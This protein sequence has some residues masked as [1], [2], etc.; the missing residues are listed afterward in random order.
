M[1]NVLHEESMELTIAHAMRHEGWIFTD[2]AKDAGFD[3]QYGIHREDVLH[4]LKTQHEDAFATAFPDD[5]SELNRNRRE[6]RLLKRLAQEL[7]RTPIVDAVTKKVSGG[8]L[9]VLRHGFTFAQSDRP[10]ATFSDLVGFYPYDSAKT[11]VVERAKANRLRVIQQV[12]FDT[13]STKTID[14]V[15]LVNGIPIVTMELKTDNTQTINDAIDQYMQKRKP[16]AST[17]LLKPGRCLVHLAVSST[18]V[19]MTTELKGPDTVFLPFNQGTYDGRA[20]NPVNPNGIATAYLWEKVFTPDLTLRIIRDYALWEPSSKGNDGRLI[21]PRFHQ[22][23]SVERFINDVSSHGTGKR[24]LIQH[25]AG[26]GKTKTIAWMAH[27]ANKLIAADGTK[28]YDCVIVVTDRTVLDKNVADGLAL[29][30][31]SEGMVINISNDETSKSAQLNE[32]LTQG[33]RIVSCTL[34]TFPALVNT[35]GRSAKLRGRRWLVII[36]EAHSSQHGQASRTLLETLAD[37]PDTEYHD[38]DSEGSDELL[39]ADNG[40]FVLDV[41][42]QREMNSAVAK[43]DNITMVGFTATPKAKT[44]AVFGNPDPDD[45]ERIDKRIPFDLYTMAQA[46]D[47]GFI[48]D[49]L[50]NYTS[51]KLFAKIEDKLGRSDDVDIA[52]AKS[53]LV[54]FVRSHEKTIRAKAEV[55]VEH[56]HANVRGLLGSTAKAMVVCSSRKDAYMWLKAVDEIIESDPKYHGMTALGAFSGTLNVSDD[57]DVEIQVTE[58]SLNAEKLPEG[59]RRMGTQEMFALD[60]YRFLIVANKYQTGFDEPRLSAMYVDK[61][62]SGVLAVQ[63]LSRLNRVMPKYNKSKTFVVDF[64]NDPTTIL[65]SFQ[66]YYAQASIDEEVDP[67]VLEDLGRELDAAGFYTPEQVEKV[68]KAV[69][70]ATG[71]TEQRTNAIRRSVDEVVQAWSNTLEGARFE[72]NKAGIEAAFAFRANLHKYVHAWDF[73]SQ[74]IDFGDVSLYHRAVFARVLAMN[75]NEDNR[76]QGADYV[77]GVELVAV[78]LDEGKEADLVLDPKA[79]EPLEVPGFESR[80]VS[81]AAASEPVQGAFRQAVEEVNKLFNA[82]G[83]DVSDTSNARMVHAV[84]E[85]LASDSAVEQLAA[86]NSAQALARADRMRGKVLDALMK[87]SDDNEKFVQ[88]LTGGEDALSV[89]V[90]A[91]SRLAR[92]AAEDNQ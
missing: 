64:V 42:A 35:I 21:F 61:A 3:P 13:K 86:K 19:Y 14:L 92:A 8:L 75:L 39:D 26:S 40:E 91:M 5:E 70:E 76:G 62:L 48:L 83:I 31:A 29:L 67:N 58:A 77:T 44:L 59:V 89:F 69:V 16:K 46:I 79:V 7:D 37:D 2:G 22:L 47:E 53:A 81:G 25:S 90:T 38:V 65:N 68:V 23:R 43:A 6:D 34:Q 55:A 71:T 54:R 10:Q 85:A 49:V 18:Q 20:G 12:H 82:A 41:K 11:D 32:Y 88:L 45:P 1:V 36:D 56:F 15:L 9:G 72:G 4:W 24:Y 17:P 51:L 84:W 57:P 78:S 73:L 60:G 87:V 80:G 52:E 28:L 50:Q 27:R 33:K 74:F 66:P 30:Q 63:T